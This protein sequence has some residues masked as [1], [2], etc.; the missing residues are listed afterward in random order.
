[1]R[2]DLASAKKTV[3]GTLKL[4]DNVLLR[5]SLCRLPLNGPMS[6]PSETSSF[7]RF[8]IARLVNAVQFSLTK[9]AE[10]KQIRTNTALWR[11][12]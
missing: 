9:G 7:A 2:F 6:C 12:N 8:R 11:T 3:R 1:M 4:P 10:F 5:C